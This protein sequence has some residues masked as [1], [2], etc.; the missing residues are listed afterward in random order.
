M[1]L[2]CCRRPGLL[3]L[4][5]QTRSNLG[6]SQTGLV[7]KNGFWWHQGGGTCSLNSVQA[8][9]ESRPEDVLVN[10]YRNQF[11]LVSDVDARPTQ[12]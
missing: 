4:I 7:T 8:M 2:R 10:T 1:M 5:L 9:L 11:F 3:R 6:L 12:V